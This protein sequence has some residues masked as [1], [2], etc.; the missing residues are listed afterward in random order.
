MKKPTI[1]IETSVIS[2]LTA[3]SSQNLIIAAHQHV[4][5]EWWEKA[6][7]HYQVFVSSVVLDEV[8][9]GDSDAVN[10]RLEKIQSFPLLEINENVYELANIYFIE[11]RLPEKARADAYHL[12]LATWHGMDFVVSWNCKHIANGHVRLLIEEI[13]AERGI[14]TPIICTPEELME[15]NI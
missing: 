8:S 5:K 10:L 1:Y 13:N 11:I 9:R 14:R 15:E 12:A 6:L 4:T 3:R 2:Y 7:P